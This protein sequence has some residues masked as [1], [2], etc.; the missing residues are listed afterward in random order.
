MAGSRRSKWHSPALSS[1]TLAIRTLHITVWITPDLRSINQ[2]LPTI[3]MLT[4]QILR[5]KVRAA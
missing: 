4:R 2:L 3:T 1:R 5:D